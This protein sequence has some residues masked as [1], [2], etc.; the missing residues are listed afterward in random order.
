MS[1][2][3]VTEGIN[4]IIILTVVFIDLIMFLSKLNQIRLKIT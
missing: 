2:N 3:L 1:V 4:G